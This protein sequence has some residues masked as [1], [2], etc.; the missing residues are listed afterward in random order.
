MFRGKAQCEVRYYLQM[1]KSTARRTGALMVAATL[2]LLPSNFAQARKASLATPYYDKLAA[3]AGPSTNDPAKS[4]NN[5]TSSATDTKDASNTSAV[6]SSTIIAPILLDGAT[7]QTASEDSTKADT[8]TPLLKSTI[9]TTDYLPKGPFDPSGNNLLIPSQSIVEISG[10]KKK[11]EITIKQAAMVNVM[12]IALMQSDDEAK[13]K[14][15][16]ILDAEKK[17]LADLWESTLTRSQD[18]QFV[19]QKLMPTSNAPHAATL[20]ARTLS[21]CMFGGIGAVGAMSPNMGTMY[22]SQMGAS[23]IMS[24]LGQVEGKQQKKAKISESESVMLYNIVRNTADKMVENYRDYTKSLAS[25]AHASEDLAALQNMAGEAGVGNPQDANH[26]L[27]MEYTLRKAQRDI[28]EKSADLRKYRQALQDLAGPDAVA[29]LD[30][31]ISEENTAV[32]SETPTSITAQSAESTTSQNAPKP[33][34]PAAQTENAENTRPVGD[35]HSDHPQTASAP[36]T[37]G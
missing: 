13:E 24:V 21:M 16:T 37:Q 32:A 31:Q 35:G 28:E 18:I 10:K 7:P 27:E 9:S 5:S 3:G 22:A 26:Q 23:M 14:V 4:S 15:E 17:Q 2:L 6:V 19:V 33:E 34:A 8:N 30:K 36:G 20:L 1:L 29:K 12:P 11:G 25:V